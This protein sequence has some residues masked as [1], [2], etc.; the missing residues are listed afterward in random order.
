MTWAPRGI[1]STKSESVGRNA[2]YRALR[3]D[4][5]TDAVLLPDQLVVRHE[6][7]VGVELTALGQGDEVAALLAVHQQH[8]VSGLEGLAHQR[9]PRGRSATGSAPADRSTR[10]QKVH[11]SAVLGAPQRA[12]RPRS[13]LPWPS[14]T[15]AANRSA[16]RWRKPK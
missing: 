7:G 10:R 15:P 6:P 4:M 3:V 1:L 9:P 5:T 8:A 13:A 11:T 2:V 12:Q 16:A 14:A